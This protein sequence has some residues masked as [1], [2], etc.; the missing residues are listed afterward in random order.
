M[1]QPNKAPSAT[2][3]AGGIGVFPNAKSPSRRWYRRRLFLAVAAVVVLLLGLAI[4][5]R[6]AVAPARETAL[7]AAAPALPP[8]YTAHGQVRPVAQAKVG[9][10]AGGEV[11]R[12]SADVGTV[13]DER[14]EI[15]RVRGPDGS[16]EIVTAPWRG[17]IA[18]LTAHVGD[19]VLPG[20]TLA[21]LDDLSRLQVETT[22]VDEFLVPHV[23]VSQSV[24]LTVEALDGREFAGRVRTVGVEPRVSSTGDASY[25]VTIDLQES[26][27]ELKPGLTT[28]I[29]FGE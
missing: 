9:T 24:T 23:R 7:P 29:T 13:V 14:Q 20:T 25:P 27:P 12:I 8:K 3:P 1:R 18:D 10:I 28:Q 2:T 22:D 21:T 19:T 6:S 17:T 5:S 26:P 15:A 16:T 4:A 11:V